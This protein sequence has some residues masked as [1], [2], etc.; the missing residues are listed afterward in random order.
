MKRI[1]T[2]FICIILQSSMFGQV[3]NFVTDNQFLI[4]KSLDSALFIIRQDYVLRDTSHINPT[5]YGREKNEYFGRMYTFAVLSDHK[6]WCD[7]K[8]RT[9][10]LSD[11]NYLQLGKAD[12]I[13]PVLS[14]IAIRPFNQ[15][16][17][18]EFLI[19]RKT[20]L[21]HYDSLL[22]KLTIGYLTI[23]DLEKGVPISQATTDSTGWLVI[24]YSAQDIVKN[25]TNEIKLLIY[26]TQPGF[27]PNE[28]EVKIKAPSVDK[29]I[30]G[31]FYF[32][33]K[34]STGK[35]E[36]ELSGVLHQ[37]EKSWVISSMP[38]ETIQKGKKTSLTPIEKDKK[39]NE[40]KKTKKQTNNV[41]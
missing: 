13:R 9:P 28:P 22:D 1:A 27:K 11:S 15:R 5:D 30:L 38:K 8:I 10:W 34:Y 19:D 24:A 39:P 12:T 32:I 18:N 35:I 21:T 29:N 2:I 17:F 6:L 41:K 20:S 16:Q 31:G 36:L 14:K 23:K 40:L 26:R 4:G 25:D 7:A 33:V 3:I 37:V